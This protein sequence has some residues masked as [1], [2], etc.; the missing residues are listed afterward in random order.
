MRVKSLVFRPDAWRAGAAGRANEPEV[1]VMRSANRRGLAAVVAAAVGAL[2]LAA[3]VALGSI[4]D[5]SGTI[6]GCF[7]TS[8]G[9]LR[10]IDPSA[11]GACTSSE[12]ALD[13]NIQG[14]QGAA[15]PTGAQGIQGPQGAQGPRGATG[16]SGYEQIHV[17]ST[18]D[19]SGN[20]TAEADC[21]A[22]KRPVMGGYELTTGLHP[23][24]TRPNDDATG[25][26][27]GVT[28]KANS[29]F[30]V[31]AICVSATPE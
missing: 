21:P 6:H 20:G 13:W 16:S 25:W 28:G 31:F 12:T 8:D 4:P 9:Q 15:G 14:A 5:A 7:K 24:E 17:Q 26:V 11:G 18:T 23:L 2:V 1:R 27:V 29:A 30:G 3:G 19:G 10:V 22:G